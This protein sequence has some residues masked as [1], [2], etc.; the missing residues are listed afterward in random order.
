MHLVEAIAA[1]H[2]AYIFYTFYKER[3]GEKF[4]RK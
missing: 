3:H 4:L 2:I 1:V